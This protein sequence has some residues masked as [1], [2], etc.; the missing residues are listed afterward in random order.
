MWRVCF[1]S[2]YRPKMSNHMLAIRCVTRSGSPLM[3]LIQS[4]SKHNKPA[5]LK[6]TKYFI[7]SSRQP[8]KLPRHFGFSDAELLLD[9][10]PLKI[11]AFQ[12]LMSI[13]LVALQATFVLC[14]F[15][16]VSRVAS[17]IAPY[18]LHS[19]LLLPTGF[20]QN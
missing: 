13:G 4:S 16:I 11:M 9:W 14:T 18:L 3:N 10:F 1:Y 17:Q 15:S 12:I 7:L 2:E 8:H 20:G 19:A 6:Q 5:R